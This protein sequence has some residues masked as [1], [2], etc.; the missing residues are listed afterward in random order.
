M[1]AFGP[2][3]TSLVALHMS[4]FGGKAD[5]TF[6]GSPLSRSLLGVKRTSLVAAHMSAYDPNA[7][8]ALCAALSIRSS[9]SF[10]GWSGP[11]IGAVI[12]AP[13]SDDARLNHPPETPDFLAPT[14][15]ERIV[16]RI[17]TRVAHVALAERELV[18]RIYQ[19]RRHAGLEPVDASRA[20]HAIADN[21][22]VLVRAHCAANF[23]GQLVPDHAALPYPAAP[24]CNRQYK[25]ERQ[26]D[27]ELNQTAADKR[28]DKAHVGKWFILCRRL[29][30][31]GGLQRCD[32]RQDVEERVRHDREHQS[33]KGREHAQPPVLSLGREAK[34]RTEHGGEHRVPAKSEQRVTG[35]E[36]QAIRRYAVLGIILRH[37]E[38][39]LEPVEAGPDQRAVDDAVAHVVELGAQKRE[40]HQDS[41]RLGDL[42]GDWRGYRR[43]QQHRCI[44]PQDLPDGRLLRH[45]GVD[46]QE[47]GSIDRQSERGR[48]APAPQEGGGEEPRRLTLTPVEIPEHGERHRRQQ[49]R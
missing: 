3:Q 6:A 4:A 29:A 38:R 20:E 14:C 28:F 39:G 49:A 48:N 21:V 30:S 8:M 33:G 13:C 45:D 46:E 1:S 43:G 17:F 25:K 40:Q 44:R 5:M 36:L 15:D 31:G 32:E 22:A 18:L 12:A 26:E 34:E 24:Q 9:A 47:E 23:I 35:A 11:P 2:K 42:L 16:L 19:R 37:I 10:A 27:H 7:D 41:Q